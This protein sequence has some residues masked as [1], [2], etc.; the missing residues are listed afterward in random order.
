MDAAQAQR[1]IES[2]RMGIP[3]DGFVRH[4]TVGRKT[5]IDG[6]S[7]QLQDQDG[8]V[9]LLKANYGSGKTHLLR[10]IREEAL[11]HDYAVSSVTLDAKGAVRFNRMDQV[12]GAVCRGIEVPGASGEKGLRSFFDLL[13]K[14]ANNR[15]DTSIWH[16]ISNN[17]KWDFSE[18]LDSRAVFIG[19]RAWATAKA[20]TQD[21]VEDW[22][23]QPWVYRGQRTK[24]Y[25]ELVE[26]LREFFRDPR[27]EWKFYYDNL[28]MFHTQGHEQSWA[29]LRDF[30]RLARASG[31]KGLIILFDEF[32]D[33]IT[34]LPNIGY[35]ESAFWNLFQFYSGKSFPGKTFFAVT[36]AFVEKCK[37]RLLQKGI[38]DYDFS[39]FDVLPTFE[40]SPLSIQ[41][42]EEL[43]IKILEAHADA[44]DWAPEVM[45]EASQLQ[46]IVRKAAS[47]QIQDRARHAI[48]SVVKSLDELLQETA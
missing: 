44:Y 48:E 37:E 42:L 27:P 30:D 35:Q 1:V 12:F 15:D 10:Y 3:P 20:E 36:P 41:E 13:I 2:L 34:N 29:A 9:L 16:K 11:D 7:R 33:I 18:E 14:D 39:R 22:F 31:L 32:E 6:L 21:L 26:D 28:F 5:E 8:T 23:S 4:F 45:M 43:A 17:W 24:L 46:Q 38:W 47:P 40:M 19:L 25:L